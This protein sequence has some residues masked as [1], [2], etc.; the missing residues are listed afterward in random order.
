MIFD[1]TNFGYKFDKKSQTYSGS[2]VYRYYYCNDKS[3]IIMEDMSDIIRV[4][5]K[6][7]THY[8]YTGKIPDEDFATL[9]LSNLDVL[10]VQIVRDI[11]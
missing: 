8:L 2:R 10:D 9:L 1:P 3:V 6:L 7:S 11:N 5:H 4:R